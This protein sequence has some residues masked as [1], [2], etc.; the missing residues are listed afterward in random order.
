[1]TTENY[2]Y[3]IAGERIP[4]GRCKKQCENCQT[5]SGLKQMGFL[6]DHEIRSEIVRNYIEKIDEKTDAISFSKWLHSNYNQVR[7]R[8]NGWVKRNIDGDVFSAEELYN[9]FTSHKK[10][11]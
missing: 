7:G 10:S 6:S 8:I 5:F 9:E 2:F 1:M 11:Q 4:L 3:C